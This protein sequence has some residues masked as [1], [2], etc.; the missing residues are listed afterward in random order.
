MHGWKR[1]SKERANR[2]WTDNGAALRGMFFETL[3]HTPEQAQITGKLSDFKDPV[4]VLDH[5]SGSMDKMRQAIF[6]KP[7][8]IQ[9]GLLTYI[10]ISSVK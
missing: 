4:E 8:I 1:S 5:L 7:H 10:S 6:S 2:F 3:I 9:I